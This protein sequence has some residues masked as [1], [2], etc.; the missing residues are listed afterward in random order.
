[1]RQGQL[2]V[3]FVDLDHFKNINDT[4]GHG[5]GDELLKQAAGRLS[6]AVGALDTV[7]RTGGDEFVLI[8][9]SIDQPGE[10]AQ[11]AERVLAAM[12]RPFDIGAHQLNVSC[13]IGISLMPD[14]GRDLQNLLMNA[15]LAMYHAKAHGR[16]TFRFY[17]REMNVEV[18]ERLHLETRL[19]RAIE[20]GEL[21]L[22][23]QP[24]FNMSGERLLGCEALVRWR[25]PEHGLIMPS[26]FIP[27]AEDTGLVV[28]LGRWVLGEACRQAAQWYD[29]GLRPVRMAVN[30][31]AR[32]LTRPD[33]V[34]DV[35]DALQS[36]GLPGYCLEIE[37]TEST[38]MEDA[39][40]AA[41]QLAVIKAMGVRLSIDD[42]GTGYSSLAYLKRFAPDTIKIDRFLH[43][44][45]ICRRMKK[46]RPSSPPSFTW[47]TPWA[48]T[49]W[50]RASNT[51][52]SKSTWAN[53]AAR[54][55]RAICWARRCP[56]KR[57]NSAWTPC[58]S[59][60]RSENPVQSLASKGETRRK[61]A[62]K[63][64]GRGVHEHVELVL[65]VQ[66]FTK[67][68]RL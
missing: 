18:A 34:D 28:P 55:C 61:R 68:S 3:L 27:I 23:Y 59:G 39:D 57:W 45:S 19:R 56:P 29:S 37:V 40:F 30:V 26:R 33:F 36:S 21:Y 42:F 20:H 64:N 44:R 53:S 41:R 50:P 60:Y 15:D 8:L 62:K 5:L 12:Q 22:V 54:R 63:R 7:G 25:D 66:R 6:A 4:L 52:S 65:T 13:S 14:D 17:T 35:R 9:P 31:S 16:S 10:A 11:V 24:Q 32:Q 67:R 38:L 2:A 43:H 49:R 58:G 1:M 51:R 48:W 47:P 46:T